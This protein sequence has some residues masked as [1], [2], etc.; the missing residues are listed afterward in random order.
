MSPG[1]L[2][3]LIPFKRF[4][5]CRQRRHQIAAATGTVDPRVD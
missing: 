5:Y 3:E 2:A 1:S 4:L